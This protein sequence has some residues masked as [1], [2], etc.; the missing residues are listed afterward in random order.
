M[1]LLVEWRFVLPDAVICGLLVIIIITF[2][3]REQSN[4]GTSVGCSMQL[5]NKYGTKVRKTGA[6]GMEVHNSVNF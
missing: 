6:A 5:N 1:I 3:L 4:F 2:N